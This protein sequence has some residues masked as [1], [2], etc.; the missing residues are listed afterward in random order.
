MTNKLETKFF[1][2]E[3]EKGVQSNQ[4]YELHLCDKLFP[5]ADV[6]KNTLLSSEYLCKQVDFKQMALSTTY[7]AIALKL[8]KDLST[9]KGVNITL[10]LIK[11]Y[12]NM[13]FVQELC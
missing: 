3:R 2:F 5:D 10:H 11:H 13:D 6:D 8:D 4:F 12:L 9:A 7:P 1:S